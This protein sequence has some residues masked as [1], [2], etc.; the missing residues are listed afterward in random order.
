M[1]A[2]TFKDETTV[3]FGFGGTYKS[4]LAFTNPHWRS[5]EIGQVYDLVVK[6]R[7]QGT[8]KGAFVGFEREG[9]KGVLV[10]GLKDKFIVD[11]ATA[12][13]M[14]LYLESKQ[15]AALALAGSTE[16]IDAAT[17]C[18]K[19]YLNA[20]LDGGNENPKTVIEG[21]PVSKTEKSSQGTGFFVS[22]NGHILTNHHVIDGCTKVDVTRVGLPPAQARVV[23][24]DKTNDLAILSSDI[25]SS[26]VPNL[27]V[28]TRIGD[29]VYVYGFPLSGLLA[30]TGNFTIGNVTA[31]AGLADD[32]RMLQISAPVQPG[33]SGGPLVDQ[34]G[35]VVGVIVSKLN[36]LKL[37][38]VTNDVS[39]NVNFAIKSTI[40]INFLEANGISAQLDAK[41][42]ARLD[43]ADIA[44]RSKQF[45]VRVNC[46]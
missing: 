34:Y 44:E 19:K 41:N 45:T 15:M 16:A 7:G 6:A 30:T 21:T 18:Q 40:A 43:G 9:V 24:S 13:S 33:N 17:A 4:F 32:T 3:W 8:W 37:A 27:S 26:D 36:A 38:S 42:L 29:N 28:R 12:G 5:I 25:R 39:Q 10:A 20:S 46:R 22:E 31:T 1:A 2:A 11:L 14:S 35:N 23:A